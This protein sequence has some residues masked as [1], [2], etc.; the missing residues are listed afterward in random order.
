VLL[1]GGIRYA[2]LHVTGYTR[3]QVEGKLLAD[4]VS[5]ENH[6][7]VLAKHRRALETERP[8]AYHERARMPAGQRIGEVTLIPPAAQ[9]GAVDRCYE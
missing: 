5:R 3:E 7:L 6:D 2:F 8:L 1:V 4:L 9:Q